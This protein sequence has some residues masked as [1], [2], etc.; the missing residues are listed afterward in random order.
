MTSI[1][2]KVAEIDVLLLRVGFVGETGWEIHFPSEYGEYMWDALLSAGKEFDITPFGVEAQRILRLEKHHIIPNQDT[3]ILST[4]LNS[5]AEWAVKFDKDD[6]IGKQALVF[7]KNKGLDSVLVG[8]IMEGQKI[9]D[10]GDPVVMDGKPIGKVTS[11]RNSP[12]FGKGFGLVW[13][14][15]SYAKEDTLIFIR[16]NGENLR[17][18]V[19]TSP[20]YDPQGEKLKL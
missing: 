1:Q 18:R 19:V 6:F 2:G 3:D 16:V 8:F 9:P 14:P 11:A 15:I 13:V 5:G 10:D 12:V 20:L 17:A 7:E 4:P